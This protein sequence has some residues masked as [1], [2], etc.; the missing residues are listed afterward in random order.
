MSTR[1]TPAPPAPVKTEAG[2]ARRAGAPY[3]GAPRGTARRRP[4]QHRA[5]GGLDAADAGAVVHVVH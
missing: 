5:V 3:K 1:T 2:A 4:L